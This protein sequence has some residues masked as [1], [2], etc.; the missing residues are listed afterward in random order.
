M[1]QTN[2]VEVADIFR[3][4]GEEYRRIHQSEMPLPQLRIMRAIEICRTREL[5]GHVEQ[6]DRCGKI[7]ISYNSCRNRHCPKCQFLMKE[8]WLLEVNRYLIP[9]QYFHVVFSITD[10]LNPLVLRNKKA[11]YDIL[12]QS[13]ARTLKELSEDPDYLGARIGFISILHT[14]GY[15]LMD[16]PHIHCIVTGGGLSLQSTQWVT[17]KK[18]FFLPVKVL[19]SRFRNKLLINLKKSHSANELKFPGTI[20]YL[21]EKPH[22]Q[23][24]IDNLF[25]K[26]WVV[27]CKPSFRESKYVVEYL[28]RY[29]HRIAIGNHRIVKVENDKVIFR[30]KDYACNSKM[31]IMSVDAFE[32]IRRFLLHVLPDRFVKIRYY[33]LLAQRNR[34]ELLKE[35]R[36]L[37]GVLPQDIDTTDIPSDWQEL[38]LMITGEDLTRCPFCGEGRMILKE[39]IPA[40]R[41]IRPP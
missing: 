41:Y 8:K 17:C 1:D 4:Y 33:G 27:Y 13:S 7:R 18:N 35:C 20:E 10:L 30:Y 12:F 6:C 29:T 38:Y 14:W 28:S 37:L 19:S 31:K 40:E 25:A 2:N 16:H 24:L 3:T 11:M 39:E 36:S 21:N 9:I 32:F 23:K 22:F 34:K 5:G 15:N 26:E